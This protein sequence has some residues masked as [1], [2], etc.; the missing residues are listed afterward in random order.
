MRNEI[1]E[2]KLRVDQIRKLQGMSKIMK[3]NSSG[4]TK[5]TQVSANP[6]YLDKEEE[7]EFAKLESAQLAYKEEFSR[8]NEL[9]NEVK[10]IKSMIQFK[11]KTL[12]GEFATWYAHQVELL[13][14]V[15]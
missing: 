12:R 1:K 10:R 9:S 8:L 6:Q 2:I 4:L 15:Q 14:E 5:D 3:L 13:N 7:R 11:Y